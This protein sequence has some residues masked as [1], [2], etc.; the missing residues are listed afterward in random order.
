M[1]ENKTFAYHSKK[2]NNNLEYNVNNNGKQKQH[3]KYI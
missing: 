1:S 3:Q 2:M